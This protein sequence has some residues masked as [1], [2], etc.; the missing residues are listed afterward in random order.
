MIQDEQEVV[1]QDEQEVVIQD[2]QEDSEMQKAEVQIL[3]YS[4]E[5]FNLSE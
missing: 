3:S 2:E 5:E 4:E 1:I